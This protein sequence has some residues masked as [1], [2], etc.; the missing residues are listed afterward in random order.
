MENTL[1]EGSTVNASVDVDQHGNDNNSDSNANAAV[2]GVANTDTAGEESQQQDESLKDE[3]TIPNT[4]DAESEAITVTA[5]QQPT[6]Q[7]NKLDSQETPST[8]ESRA[9]NVFGQDNEDSD[10]LFG[11]TESSVSNNEA[12][13]PSIPTNPV[14]SE[15]N[16]P[17][18]KEDS[19]IQDSNGDV[20]NMED[21]KIQKE[22]EPE[23]NTVIE[24]VKEESQP[25]E[26][27]K[28]MDEV[29][30]DDEDEDQPMISPD[31]SIFGDTKSESKQLGNTSSVANT[32]SEI[33]DA[34]KA[35][36][37]D[38]IE[39]TES[40]DK[41]V[42]SGEERN[43]QEREIMNDHSKSANPKKT[44]I[45]RV[46]PETFEIPQA[47]EIV[48]PSY[49]KW[50]NLEKIHS[51]EV[52]SLPEFFTN[53]IPSK[54]P[55][56]YMRYRNFMVNSY[57]LNPNE[58]F[59]VTTARRNVSGDAA[60]LFRL[61]KFLTKWGLINYQVDSKLLPKNIEPH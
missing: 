60:A 57:R 31:N 13:T 41:K 5:K 2:A 16:K 43:E 26:N 48:I 44:T 20:K 9:Q 11:E 53:R 1:G 33:P 42:D 4:R 18:I 36:Q 49:S 34:H 23:N 19:T 45:T 17:A 6:M 46:E 27:T 3:A 28:E 59:S 40:V 14:D 7:A 37:E 32:P 8:E 58:Y 50:F 30:E 56:V 21:V 10:N 47:H 61:H 38:T 55:E 39:K 29:E 35:E 22:E 12:N 24:G 25:D 51:I 15:N 52:Q 54:T